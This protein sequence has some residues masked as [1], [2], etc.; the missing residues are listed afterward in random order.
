MFGVVILLAVFAAGFGLGYGVRAYISIK[1][2]H[3][4]GIA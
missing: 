1:R 2:R 4:A 3:R